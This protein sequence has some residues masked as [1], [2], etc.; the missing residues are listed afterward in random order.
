M[1][2]NRA[3]AWKNLMY[4]WEF[5]DILENCEGG[6]SVKGLLYEGTSTVRCCELYC[7]GLEPR[8]SQG[9]LNWCTWHMGTVPVQSLL[10]AQYPLPNIVVIH[11][12]A[13]QGFWNNLK[14]TYRSTIR[15]L[16]PFYPTDHPAGTTQRCTSSDKRGKI[17]GKALCCGCQTW[18][19]Y[20]T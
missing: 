19:E 7:G 2:I 3:H 20:W 15:T 9:K 14:M 11:L 6:W 13:T 1:D 17:G 18:A 10:R 5:G 4:P 8:G 16:C 12:P